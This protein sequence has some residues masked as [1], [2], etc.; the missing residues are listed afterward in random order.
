MSQ[1]E[2]KPS[3]WQPRTRRIA[4]TVGICCAVVLIGVTIW[5]ARI[6]RVGAGYGAKIAAS[7]MFVAGRSRESIDSGRELDHIPFVKWKV[8]YDNDSVTA[9]IGPIRRIAVRR[10]GLGTVLLPSGVTD[11]SGFLAPANDQTGHDDDPRLWP[12]GDLLDKSDEH[13]KLASIV[14]SAFN[15]PTNDP[16]QQR[17]IRA[18]IVVHDGQIVAEQYAKG[19]DRHTPL[20][21]WSMTKSIIGALTGILVGQGKLDIHA[22]PVLPEWSEPGD[23]RSTITLDHLLRMSSGLKF[24]EVYEEPLS[25]VC[26]MLFTT[27]DAGGFAASRR[28]EADPNTV[29][30]YSSGTTNIISKVLRNSVAD[31][32]AYH[33]MP[34]HF[35]DRIGM[36]HAVIETDPS[37]T[38]VGSSL[39]WATARDWARFGML[40]LHDGVWQG[41]RVLP[42]GWVE[43]CRTPTAT[44][45]NGEYGA[46]W[47]CNAGAVAGDTETRPRPG[48]P[49]DYYAA[50]GFQ[51]QSVSIFPSQNLV[52][53]KLALSS[54]I[55]PF[56]EESFLADVL[57]AVET[58]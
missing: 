10:P 34:R 7:S 15:E 30:K 49:A 25:D 22:A 44:S 13:D 12:M 19:F 4:R 32:A 6:A 2:L 36:R 33:A 3:S 31:D 1:I 26:R 16:E 24:G 50:R 57:S 17:G 9:W 45:P 52:V 20:I 55:D 38:F 27:D 54:P 51:G 29:W 40:Y 8:N 37:G 14:N 42:E 41:E 48:L 35:F 56:D 47:W 11:A 39:G 5:L 58:N 43:Y 21:G 46:Q 18:I 23:P 28:L 53:V